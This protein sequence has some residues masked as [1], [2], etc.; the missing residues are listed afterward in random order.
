MKHSNNKKRWVTT[1]ELT[2]MALLLA[3]NIVLTRFVSFRP[4]PSVRVSFG[5]L[6]DALMAMLV[7]PWKAGIVSAVWD[8]LNVVLFQPFAPFPGFTLSAFLGSMFYGLFLYRRNV[9]WYHVLIPVVI[10]TLF[11]NLF[12]NTLW[13][14]I[15][16]GLPV[17]AWTS[18]A[19]MLPERMLSNG[20]M[21]PIRFIF[22]WSFAN[23]PQ[24]K[25]I[26]MKISSAPE[27]RTKL[28]KKMDS[29]TKEEDTE[30][31]DA[32]I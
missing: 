2:T 9:R 29:L 27:K 23:T 6:P 8:V 20:I 26:W 17:Y 1:R 4:L 13:N 22:I 32:K 3:I 16:A 28:D 14:I 12:L 19:A 7:G 31:I 30:A 15:L 24:L 11:V 25:R 10:N 21:G 5:F 18:W